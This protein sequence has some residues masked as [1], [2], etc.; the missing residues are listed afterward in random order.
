MKGQEG[1]RG[2]KEE[3]KPQEGGEGIRMDD[4]AGVGEVGGRVT[5][6]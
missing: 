6:V 4:R 3:R 5:W 1:E 2:R